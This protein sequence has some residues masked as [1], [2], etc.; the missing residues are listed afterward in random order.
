MEISF[1]E[2]K[3]NIDD[4]EFECTY[5]KELKFFDIE[6]MS[7]II[8]HGNKGSGKTIKIY[9]FLCSLLDKRVYTLKN[10]QVE[11][12]KKNF[13]FRSSIYH[14]EIDCLEL[15]NNERIFFNNYLKDY[16]GTRNIGLDLPKIIYIMNIDVIHRNSLLFLRKLIES[17]YQSCKFIFETNNISAIPNSLIT[18]FLSFRISN[19]LK[20]EIEEVLKKYIK[21]KKIKITKNNLNKII[22][23][24]TNYKYNNNLNDIFIAFN[25]YL[26]TNKILVNN[27]NNIVNEIINI[28]TCKNL[29]FESVQQ[30]KNI[31]EKIFINCYDVT[32]IV[33]SINKIL[34][35]K[36][37]KNNEMCYK[38]LDLSVKCDLNLV[39][40][41][42]KYFIHLENYFIKLILLFNN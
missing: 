38:I 7:N 24:N 30:L 4:V 41:T 40:S 22:N 16:C 21:D 13:K 14:L 12:E 42:G 36:Y 25:Y 31:C 27:C 1:F 9:A 28:I 3:P 18:R 8:F 26:K 15:I 34:F 35:D 32:S 5:Y 29:N 10:N 19:P 37:K 23:S 2:T 17:N 6:S 39:N 11:I 33:A 20:I